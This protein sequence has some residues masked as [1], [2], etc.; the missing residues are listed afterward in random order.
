MRSI[1]G[2]LEAGRRVV[3]IDRS[4]H[5]AKI[6][7]AVMLRAAKTAVQALIADISP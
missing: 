4:A 7:V 5:A 3:R 2:D 1:S 6:W